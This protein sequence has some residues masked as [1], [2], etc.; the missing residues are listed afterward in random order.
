MKAAF[1][2]LSL[3]GHPLAP[4]S[5]RL[6]S[7]DVEALCGDGSADDKASGLADD[8]SKCVS[9]ETAAKQQPASIRLTVP[10]GPRESCEILATSGGGQSYVDLLTC[11][12]MAG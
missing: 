1:L 8:A 12:Q 7:Y 2:A 9:D 11:L 4:V 5:D 6:P 3:L 10:A